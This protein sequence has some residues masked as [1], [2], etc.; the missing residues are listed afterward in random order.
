MPPEP[1]IEIIEKQINGITFTGLRIFLQLPVT[2]GGQQMQGPFIHGPGDDDSAAVTFWGKRDL[3]PTLQ[4]A[5]AM[6]DAHYAKR[7]P[8]AAK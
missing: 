3:R 4:Q 6:L 7:D 1:V 5:L 2:V 8:N